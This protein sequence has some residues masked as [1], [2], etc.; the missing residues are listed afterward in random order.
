ML[1]TAGLA[2]RAVMGQ[3]VSLVY[4]GDCLD[5]SKSGGYTSGELSRM[6]ADKNGCITRAEARAA[7]SAPDADAAAGAAY[8]G[9]PPVYK[10]TD[11]LYG[12][13]VPAKSGIYEAAAQGQPGSGGTLKTGTGTAGIG[14]L[15]SGG[16][17]TLKA[18]AIGGGTL[19]SGTGGILKAVR[20][21]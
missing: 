20:Q 11:N 10:I 2:A 7:L 21:P 9:A 8:L 19:K 3:T 15:K 16:S 13:D 17:G 14:V 6:D 1:I 12:S 4:S 5:T 18:G